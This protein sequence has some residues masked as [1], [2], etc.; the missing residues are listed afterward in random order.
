M[1][2]IVDKL[3]EISYATHTAQNLLEYVLEDI[4]TGR[5]AVLANLNRIAS[6]LDVLRDKLCAI[7]GLQQSLL[8][9]LE[10]TKNAPSRAGNSSKGAEEKLSN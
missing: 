3:E 5:E 4:D 10:A 9:E 2:A 6:T 8:A 1:V 7:D